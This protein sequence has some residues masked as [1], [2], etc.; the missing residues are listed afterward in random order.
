MATAAQLRAFGRPDL[1]KKMVAKEKAAVTAKKAAAMKA[2]APKNVAPMGGGEAAGNPAIRKTIAPSKPNPTAEQGKLVATTTTPVTS[3]TAIKPPTHPELGT[4]G[5]TA[6]VVPGGFEPRMPR[7][8]RNADGTVRDFSKPNPNDAPPSNTG[9]KYRPPPNPHKRPTGPHPNA[10]ARQHASTN[11]RFNRGAG[12][13]RKQGLAARKKYEAAHP[14]TITPPTVPELGTVGGKAIVPPEGFINLMPRPYGEV[15]GGTPPV[16]N[17]QPR[18]V[19]R[20]T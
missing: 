9:G 14:K 18:K 1:A 11:A 5:G 6:V 3:S 10:N 17:D 19:V 13:L 16:T 7:P 2:A 8:P 4:V 15:R 20:R 12:G